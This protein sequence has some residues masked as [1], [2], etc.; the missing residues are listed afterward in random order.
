MKFEGN[1]FYILCK[2]V[3]SV[4]RVPFTWTLCCTLYIIKSKG[5]CFY[6]DSSSHWNCL[7]VTVPLDL[8]FF[9]TVSSVYEIET[10]K[11]SSVSRK[12][13]LTGLI[14]KPLIFGKM[15]PHIFWFAVGWSKAAL[16]H[17]HKSP[18]LKYTCRVVIFKR[19]L[20]LFEVWRHFQVYTKGVHCSF[21]LFI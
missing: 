8:A 5:V 1:C 21:Y 6:L 11:W 15:Y 13:L 14:K 10:V 7:E 2:V 18:T 19:L 3:G 12:H 20:A 9:F 4:W 16:E 17:F